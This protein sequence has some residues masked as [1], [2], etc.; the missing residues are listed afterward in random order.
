MSLVKL[1]NWVIAILIIVSAYDL[2][3]GADSKK[4][5]SQLQFENNILIEETNI[6]TKK[7]NT[8]EVGIQSRQ[9][10]DAHAEHFARKEL[11]LIYQDEKFL[12]FQEKKIDEPNS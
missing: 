12:S 4:I 7:N 5:F 6:L 2:F 3:F 11:N 1:L 9:K 10:N 8:L